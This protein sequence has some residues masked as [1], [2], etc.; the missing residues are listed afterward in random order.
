MSFWECME[1]MDGNDLGSDP[2]DRRNYVRLSRVASLQQEKEKMLE[3][4]D[5]LEREVFEMQPEG[6]RIDIVRE[7][8]NLE[9][10]MLRDQVA[11]GL[12][13]AFGGCEICDAEARLR[14][15][16][17]NGESLSICGECKK[18]A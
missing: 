9:R 16:N 1:M 14:Q 8:A 7:F 15:A 4:L 2:V 10:N 18:R 17:I 3:G 11:R 13:P 12:V 6:V 5:A